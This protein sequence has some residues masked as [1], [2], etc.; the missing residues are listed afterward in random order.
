MVDRSAVRVTALR[1][2]ALCALLSHPACTAFAADDASKFAMKG[3]GFLP[4]QIYVTE[5]GKRSEIYYMIGG[6]VEGY[7]SA[8]N[9]LTADTYDV[10]SFESLELLLAVMDKHCEANPNDRLHAVFSAMIA[11][12]AADRIRA[13]SPRVEIA[14]DGR[15]TQLY[16]E[17]IRRVQG[18]LA[19]LGLYRGE[20]DGTFSDQTRSAIIAF[21]SDLGFATTGFPDQTTL[22]RLLRK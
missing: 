12:I 9:R 1:S 20:I 11:R 13:E 2:L 10:L 8:Y 16:R 5:R 6:W 19:R 14:E 3:A 4:C 22:W 7:V 17:A 15:R 21:Q 18:E